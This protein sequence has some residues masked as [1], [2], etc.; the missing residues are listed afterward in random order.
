MTGIATICL[1][2]GV[3]SGILTFDVISVVLLVGF[4]LDPLADVLSLVP[5]FGLFSV[6]DTAGVSTLLVRIDVRSL[7]LLAGV[8]GIAFDIG[9]TVVATA[10]LVAVVSSGLLLVPVV[11]PF[12]FSLDFLA[13]TVGMADVA[14]FCLIA[15]VSSGRLLVSF[16]SGL[17]VAGIS[18]LLVKVDVS[19]P[20]L[21]AGE[22]AGISVAFLATG[23]PSGILT[24]NVSPIFLLVCLVVVLV[25]IGVSSVLLLI[26][27]SY[28][29]PLFGAI[30]VDLLI[31]VLSISGLASVFSLVFLLSLSL[32]I[33]VAGIS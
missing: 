21:L 24:G 5:P 9:M 6:L 33:G 2:A 25:T 3:S 23:V 10:C 16:I 32:T 11:L 1:T 19:S 13:G 29:L 17:G 27:S 30:Y 8:F 14:I 26:C 4:S 31:D 20:D 18:N 12:G 7:D 22:M 28:L 15:G